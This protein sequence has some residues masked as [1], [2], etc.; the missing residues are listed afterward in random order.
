MQGCELRNVNFALLCLL[1][2]IFAFVHHGI[3]GL[4]DLGGTLKLI[5]L[6]PCHGQRN[7]LLDQV[8]SSPLQPGLE[9]L[10]M[11]IFPLYSDTLKV[12]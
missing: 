7:L 8:V 2:L 9:H 10:I 3:M 6:F 11:D 12:F 1:S 4:L 5:Q